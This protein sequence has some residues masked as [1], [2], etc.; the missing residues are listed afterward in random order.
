MSR[1]GLRPQQFLEDLR[2]GA[3]RAVAELFKGFATTVAGASPER[4]EQVMATPAGRLVLEAIFWQMPRQLDRRRG[5]TVSASVRWRITSPDGSSE[6]VYDLIVASGRARVQRGERG[7]E[8]PVSITLDRVA[9]LRIASG[10]AD[11]MAAYFRGELAIA[12]DL[13]VA[14]KLVSLFRV[15][16]GGRPG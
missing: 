3:D 5:R 14:A 13:M 2:H 6:T 8:P 12:G 1:S 16:R 11:P 15:P 7:T 9:F 4:L 10:A